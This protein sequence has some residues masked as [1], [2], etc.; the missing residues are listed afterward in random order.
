MKNYRWLLFDADETLFDFPQSER[1]AIT[2]TLKDY[3]LPYD[4]KTIFLYSQINNS[5]WQRFN[6]NEIPRGQIAQDRFT[7]LLEELGGDASL[8]TE[9]NRHY[10]KSLGGFGILLPGALEMCRTLSRYFELAIITNGFS[11]SQHGRFD[12]SPVRE[13]I[14]HLFI[15]EDLGCQKPQKEFFD[16]VLAAMG[17]PEEQKNQV[18][19][20]GDSLTSDIQGGVN[21]G[22]DT[23]WYC[24]SGGQDLLPT[25]IVRNYGELLDLLEIPV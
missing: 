5:L 3:G 2:K 24:P 25:Y 17:I 23:C 13:F 15:S 8:G 18:L 16:K 22:L 7:R 12:R 19:V 20:I 4:E 1:L 11:I 9:M 21:S 6:R 14:P 10:T